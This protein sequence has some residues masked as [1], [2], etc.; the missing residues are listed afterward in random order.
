MNK[1][2][3]S[4][5][6]FFRMLA[7]IALFLTV[8]PSVGMSEAAEAK[9]YIHVRAASSMLA[10]LR[11]SAE[12]YMQQHPNM[13]VTVTGAQ[14]G[15]F[16]GVKSIIEGTSDI[17]GS[18]SEPDEVH[19][20]MMEKKGV[21]VVGDIVQN[22]A[23]VPIIHAGN[24]VTNLS[25]KQLKQIYIGE[26]K[27]WSEVGGKDLPI[28]V[29]SQLGNTGAYETWSK[30]VLEGTS[31]VTPSASFLDTVSTVKSAETNEG[32]IAYAGFTNINTNKAVKKVIVDGIEANEETIRNS[33]FKIKR[34]LSLY[35]LDG[36]SKEVKDFVKYVQTQAVQAQR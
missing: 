29:V 21:K 5:M 27:N 20:Q 4:N 24:P 6:K 30:I 22:D 36:S 3:L 34:S 23:V 28:L 26:I 2:G 33:T 25:L 14:S 9:H 31:M 32:T 10:I 19:M 11:T 7:F 18:S 8:L 13:V 17:G 12:S 16:R 1:A 35:T 15:S